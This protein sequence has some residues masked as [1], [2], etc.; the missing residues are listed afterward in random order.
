MDNLDKNADVLT[1]LDS[2]QD[3]A[4]EYEARKKKQEEE[5]Q[6]NKEE[7]ERALAQVEKKKKVTV[8][9]KTIFFKAYF[10]QVGNYFKNV[11]NWRSICRKNNTPNEISPGFNTV[12]MFSM[13]H[14]HVH[15]VETLLK[16]F[17]GILGCQFRT[18]FEII[19]L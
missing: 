18:F 7:A 10:L 13:Y 1:I 5:E 16:L 8:F 14:W 6:K 19:A 11:R 17:S 15:N 2:L 12:D 3:Y 4:A 9:S